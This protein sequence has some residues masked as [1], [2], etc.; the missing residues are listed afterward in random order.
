MEI[1]I[2]GILLA[3]CGA[4]WLVYRIAATLKEPK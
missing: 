3:L 1:M 4:T 2:I